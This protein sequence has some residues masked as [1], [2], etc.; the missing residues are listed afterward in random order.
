MES[1]DPLIL[2]EF[3]ALVIEDYLQRKRLSTT[4]VKFREER[5]KISRDSVNIWYNVLQAL[6]IC[7]EGTIAYAKSSVPIAHENISR[8]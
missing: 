3:S 2:E 8:I 7:E 1:L 4:Q 6:E 5:S